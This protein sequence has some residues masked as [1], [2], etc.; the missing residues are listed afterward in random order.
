[1]KNP[2]VIF[3]PSE[4]FW[5]SDFGWSSYPDDADQ[6]TEEQVA[7]FSKYP[8]YLSSKYKGDVS[9]QPMNLCAYMEFD[10]LVEHII[11][12]VS[13]N[14]KGVEIAN[15]VSQVVESTI[16]YCDD[17][18]F[19]DNGVEADIDEVMLIYRVALMECDCDTLID[20]VNRIDEVQIWE[21]D[22]GFFILRAPL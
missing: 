18:V 9:I 7:Y 4:G 2:H 15:E 13:S 12:I 20:I 21:T 6:L 10:E 3:S 16:E 1:M 11:S 19:L 5:L 8:I 22:V 14:E 17:S